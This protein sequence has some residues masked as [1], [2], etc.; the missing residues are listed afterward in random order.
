MFEHSTKL[1]LMARI[2]KKLN[3]ELWM[4]NDGRIEYFAAKE[5]GELI[6]I[7]DETNYHDIDYTLELLALN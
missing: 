7:L 2:E 3:K 4:H 6:Y 5:T 1:K